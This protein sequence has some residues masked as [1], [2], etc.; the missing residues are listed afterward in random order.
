MARNK[1]KARNNDGEKKKGGK[2]NSPNKN[3][4]GEK[5]NNKGGGKNKS[6][7]AQEKKKPIGEDAYGETSTESMSTKESSGRSVHSLSSIDM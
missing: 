5:K 2:N 1:A 6:N 7:E 4:K 3:N